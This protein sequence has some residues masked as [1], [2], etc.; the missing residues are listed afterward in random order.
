MWLLKTHS[1]TSKRPG[2]EAR[3]TQRKATEGDA[4]PITRLTTVTYLPNI[5]GVA[6]GS[7]TKM[8]LWQNKPLKEALWQDK[9]SS[10]A[11]TTK[12]QALLSYGMM[13]GK[14]TL[15]A[16]R[17]GAGGGVGRAKITRTRKTENT[18]TRKTENTR[19]RKTKQ[20]CASNRTPRLPIDR[21]MS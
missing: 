3:K 1:H 8:E 21:G 9:P 18:R 11:N 14:D 2:Y 20:S 19:T 12:Q 10:K 15:V 4:D 16:L 17:F 7:E 13:S 5:A 6:G